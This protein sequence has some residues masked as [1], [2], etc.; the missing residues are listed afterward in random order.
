[1]Q[2]HVHD[3]RGTSQILKVLLRVDEP[4]AAVAA[5]LV[6]EELGGMAVRRVGACWGRIMRGT[7]T[8]LS[9]LVPK[10]VSLMSGRPQNRK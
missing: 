4:A 2:E 8:L 7:R 9:Q 10:F 6:H 1:M 5:D 3:E